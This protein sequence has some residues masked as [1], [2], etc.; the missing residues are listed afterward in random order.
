MLKN[1]I[2]GILKCSISIGNITF[3]Y[4]I[5]ST[6]CNDHFKAYH[7]IYVI[8]YIRQCSVARLLYNFHS[9]K[10]TY[11]PQIFTRSKYIFKQHFDQIQLLLLSI[12]I[13]SHFRDF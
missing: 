12:Y 8:T 2:T 13:L 4:E 5:T 3:H 6:V 11:L 10:K 7:I 1:L 9:I